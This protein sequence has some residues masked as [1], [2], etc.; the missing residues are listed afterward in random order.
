MESPQECFLH[1][2]WKFVKMSKNP[3]TSRDTTSTKQTSQT[4]NI[5]EPKKNAKNE[6]RALDRSNHGITNI[7]HTSFDHASSESTNVRP[8]ITRT[9]STSRY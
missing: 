3:N 1:H 9:M 7:Q 2:G 6:R 5:S 4:V 8:N